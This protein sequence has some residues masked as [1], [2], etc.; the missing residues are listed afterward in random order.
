[1]S[2]LDDLLVVQPPDVDPVRLERRDQ[3]AL[4]RRIPVRRQPR[5]QILLHR[6][7]VPPPVWIP[8][9]GGRDGVERVVDHLELHPLLG[10]LEH[11]HV[12]VVVVERRDG[13]R[14]HDLHD[15]P[16]A[17][18]VLPALVPTAVGLAVPVR[19]RGV[20]V[21]EVLVL[22]AEIAQP[23]AVAVGIRGHDRG[24]S[25]PHERESHHRNLPGQGF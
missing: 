12:L 15:R 1:M 4:H 6:S 25:H 13:H 3:L 19:V 10:L 24:E 23:V 18:R 20:G 17:V 21:R 11:A 9:D 7:R 5:R 14:A 8:P 22:F 16:D 2:A